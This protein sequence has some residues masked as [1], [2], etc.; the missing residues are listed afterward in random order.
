[1]HPVHIGSDTDGIEAMGFLVV[2]DS[3]LKKT[4]GLQQESLELVE[5]DLTVLPI[6][7]TMSALPIDLSDEI[8]VKAADESPLSPRKKISFSSVYLT[9]SLFEMKTMFMNKINTFVNEQV[10]WISHQSYDPKKAS[11]LAPMAKFPFLLHQIL[12]MTGGVV[13]IIKLY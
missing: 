13:S 8:I 1:M 9:K 12:E 4:L 10:S 2:L 5:Q 6:G 7:G 11:V 3:F